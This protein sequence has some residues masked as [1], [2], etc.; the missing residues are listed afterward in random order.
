LH[1][2]S[3]SGFSGT[4]T[5]NWLHNRESLLA[6]YAKRMLQ[7]IDSVGSYWHGDFELLFD[8]D[9]SM[10]GHGRYFLCIAMSSKNNDL[11]R[12]AVDALIAAV[13]ECRIGA[14]AFGEAMAA[15]LPTGVITSVRWTRGLRDMSR[16]SPLHAQFAWQVVSSL[17]EKAAITS[18]Q[19][20]PF[21]E[22]LTELQ[23]EYGFQPNDTLVQV[24]TSITGGGKGAKLAKGILAFKG[25]RKADLPAALQDLE[26]R[27]N[28]A[29]R[30]QNWIRAGRKE[31][32]V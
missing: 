17:I 32:F 14:T 5:Y 1:D 3:P 29:E 23:I 20:I 2:N 4:E 26:S 24:L 10:A 12:L 11:S 28:R 21:L 8:P 9:I 7:N 27:I 16:T 31:A 30:W 22:L 6:L 18:T 13:G 15:F 25:E 19:Q